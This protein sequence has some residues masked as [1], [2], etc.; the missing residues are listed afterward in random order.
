MEHGRLMGMNITVSSQLVH[1][2]VLNK[3]VFMTGNGTAE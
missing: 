2:L 1:I 3:A